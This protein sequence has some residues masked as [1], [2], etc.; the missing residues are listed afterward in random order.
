MTNLPASLLDRIRN[1]ARGYDVER[2]ILFGS[3]ARGDARPKSDI[4][5]AVFAGPSF[6]Q[7]GRLAAEVEELPTLLD[8][9]L[10]FV[11]EA[12]GPR[13][14]D[15]IAREGVVIYERSDGKA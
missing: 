13:I 8:V 5:L 3:R 7:P 2:V 15:R 9:D 6:T 11:D 10:V 1:L 12:I 14:M 4:D